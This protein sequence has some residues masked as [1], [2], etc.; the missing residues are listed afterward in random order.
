MHGGCHQDIYAVFVCVLF[1]REKHRLVQ[2][3]IRGDLQ[4]IAGIVIGVIQQTAQR[5]LAPQ[6]CCS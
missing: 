4:Q 6:N 2:I 3:P 5:E 1:F